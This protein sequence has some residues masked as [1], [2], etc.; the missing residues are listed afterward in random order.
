M[1]RRYAQVRPDMWLDDDW[2]SLTPH[3][4]HLYLV[5]LTDP[6]LSYA[7]VA[8]WKPGRLRQR[9]NEWNAT[10]LIIAAQEC[11]D[12]HFLIFDDETE[13]VSVRSFLRHDG[14]MKQPRMAVS[15]A[16]AF[17]QIGSNKIRA[18]VVHELQ[19]LKRENPDWEAW[20]KPQVMTVLKQ[21][22]V[23][24]RDMVTD[25]AIPLG[26]DLGMRLPLGLGQSQ[27]SVSASP[28]PAPTPTPS[29]APS[30]KE[31]AV[32]LSASY[33]QAVRAS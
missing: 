22:A 9:A 23:N 16:L 10:D 33:P 19:R 25:L 13:E 7:G 14:L 15:M 5:L 31:D 3:A 30:S 26:M 17:G 32:P 6:G 18:A 20:T 11:S 28:T 27:P 29:P 24:P 2:R 4:Q 8:E 21:N 12:R 1:A